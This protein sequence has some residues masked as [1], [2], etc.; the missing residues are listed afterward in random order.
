MGRLV[1]VAINESASPCTENGKPIQ[2]PCCEDTSQEL[3]VDELTK[4]SFDFKSTTDLYLLAA[5]TYVLLE[6]TYFSSDRQVEYYHY[7][8]PLPDQDIRVLHQVFLI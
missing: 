7:A 4:S 8:P 5:I 3:K 2:M 6:D 1:S